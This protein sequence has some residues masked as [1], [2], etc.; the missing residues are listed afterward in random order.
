M[1]VV[2]LGAKGHFMLEVN[3]EHLANPFKDPMLP[4]GCECSGRKCL[5]PRRWLEGWFDGR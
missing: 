3:P 5:M 4:F 1:N 2:P